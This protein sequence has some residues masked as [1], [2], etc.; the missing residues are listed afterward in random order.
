MHWIGFAMAG[1]FILFIVFLFGLIM[2]DAWGRDIINWWYR[3]RGYR[4]T[5]TRDGWI[6]EPKEK[7]K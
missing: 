4:I 6:Y 7:G 1:F 3:I 5:N 2:W